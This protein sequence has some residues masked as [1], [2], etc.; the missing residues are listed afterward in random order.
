MMTELCF[1]FLQRLWLMNLAAAP[2]FTYTGKSCFVNFCDHGSLLHAIG[3][4]GGMVLMA[5]YLL[6]TAQY[7]LHVHAQIEM[8]P[9]PHSS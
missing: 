7:P 4:I 3:Y 5:L 1:N 2:E 8:C 9:V 6:Y